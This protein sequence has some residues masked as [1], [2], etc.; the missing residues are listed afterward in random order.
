M[1]FLR[2]PNVE[3]RGVSAC[4]P[5]I[6]DDNRTTSLV[7]DVER[8]HLIETTGV[9]QKRITPPISALLTFA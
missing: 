3:L 9:V 4:V 7:P 6:V 1:A 8:E 2:F 5:K